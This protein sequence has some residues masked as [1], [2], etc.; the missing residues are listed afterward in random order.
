MIYYFIPPT[1]VYTL[2]ITRY[3]VLKMVRVVEK[4]AIKMSIFNKFD[5]F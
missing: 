5:K 4:E 1:S 3:F 2:H